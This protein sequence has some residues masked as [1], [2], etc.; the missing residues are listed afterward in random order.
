M[1]VIYLELV[2]G[3]YIP[4]GHPGRGSRPHGEDHVKAAE[5]LSRSASVSSWDLLPMTLPCCCCYPPNLPRWYGYYLPDCRCLSACP[6]AI[7]CSFLPLED[8][9]M[10]S[11]AVV[12][13]AGSFA[14]FGEQVV[15]DEAARTG[16][17]RLEC[18]CCRT[19]PTLVA[20]A[21]VTVVLRQR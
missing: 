17:E 16:R 18:H 3:M 7:P 2:M 20:H 9:A 19:S 8:A 11:S 14:W 12:M 10:T 13:V 15:V 1:S 5:D 6:K 21:V 4:L